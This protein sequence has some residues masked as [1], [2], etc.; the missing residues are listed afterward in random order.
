VIVTGVLLL[1]SAAGEGLHW[2]A[3]GIIITL[4]GAVWNAWVLLI[5]ILR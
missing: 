3:A 5:D 4:V 1:T 2:L